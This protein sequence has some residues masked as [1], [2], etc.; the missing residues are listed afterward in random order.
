M[1]ILEL[2]PDVVGQTKT[3]VLL[4]EDDPV[5][6]WLVRSI[7]K[8]ECEFMTAA[9]A[10]K[11]CHAYCTYKP[12]LVFLDIN[13]PDE[14][15]FAVLNFIME[16]DPEGFVIMFSSNDSMDNIMRAMDSGA[17]GFIVKPFFKETLLHYVHS[18]IGGVPA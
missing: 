2:S 15:G 8:D 10:E 11:A 12:S 4:V 6:R 13:L 14:D 17:R 1:S 9:T 18:A 7:L 5:T 3:L 16:H